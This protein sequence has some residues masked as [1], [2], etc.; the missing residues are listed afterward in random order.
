MT[1]MS[2]SLVTLLVLV[3][4]EIKNEQQRILN[5]TLSDKNFIVDDGASYEAMICDSIACPYLCGDKR[6][7]CYYHDETELDRNE[8][9]MCKERWLNSEVDK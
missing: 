6:A 4:W 5:S 3:R 9:F 1:I 8:C 7:L 2:I